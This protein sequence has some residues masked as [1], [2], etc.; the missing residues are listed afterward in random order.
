MEGYLVLSLMAVVCAALLWRPLMNSGRPTATRAEYEL[1][2]YKDQ[3]NE[4]ERDRGRGIIS[5]EE[6]EASRLEIS[7]KIINCG[8]I[9]ASQSI[10]PQ[11]KQ[12]RFAVSVALFIP[13]A[14]SLIYLVQGSPGLKG[15]SVKIAERG[16]TT[17]NEIAPQLRAE[18]TELRDRLEK[19]PN[20]LATWVALGRTLF[21]S[22]EFAQAA[23]TYMQATTIFP[24]NAE[25]FARAGEALVYGS[26][27]VV[28]PAAALAFKRSLSLLPNDARSRYYLALGDQ[29]NGRLEGALRKW[30]ELAADSPPDA[31]WQDTLRERIAS[32]SEQIGKTSD[33]APLISNRDQDA[34]TDND[35]VTPGP[36][37][38]DIAAAQELSPEDRQEM[39]RSMVDR[40]AT[41]LETNPGDLAGWRRLA[42]ARKV[43]GQKAE[44]KAALGKI[45][46]LE[47]KNEQAQLDYLTAV[48]E[49]ASPQLPSS[50]ELGPTLVRI[51]RRDDRN[52]TALWYSGL[53]AKSEGRN[54][55]A[56]KHWSNLLS[57]SDPNSPRYVE[58]KDQI[59]SLRK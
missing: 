33:R 49:L 46:A 32:L 12:A 47:P 29:Q 30:K 7:R 6:A 23:Q 8:D 25:L 34:R 41:R 39:I 52:P 18:I 45:A 11:K 37:R 53:L 27:G 4:V 20:V 36:S 44:E 13:V 40:L 38:E 58:L 2:F 24:E 17:L 56:I 51:L 57:V 14:A 31:P 26:D 59:S 19:K 55:D 43:L 10:W 16:Q 21:R 54:A 3:L 50:A 42:R 28:V 5:I 15:S 48:V 22:H 9:R 1:E 35:S